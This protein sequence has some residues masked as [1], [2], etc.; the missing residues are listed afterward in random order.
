MRRNEDMYRV[1]FGDHYD[2]AVRLVELSRMHTRGAV[3][4]SA[5]AY[6]TGS[7]VSPAAFLFGLAKSATN[8]V[9]AAVEGAM[10]ITGKKT[11]RELEWQKVVRT[12]I[13]NPEFLRVLLEMPTTR[14]LPEWQA[15]WQ[16]LLAKS[17][18]RSAARSAVQRN[19][20]SGENP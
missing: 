11:A 15:S 18:A 9:Q 10:K 3:G 7:G 20:E 4:T 8:P 2:D 12:A 17:S 13:E 16:K 5:E 19:A 14:S 1:I 6:K